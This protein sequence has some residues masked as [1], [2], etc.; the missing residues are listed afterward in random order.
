MGPLT[1][2]G[3]TKPGDLVPTNEQRLDAIRQ[4][5]AKVSTNQWEPVD[6]WRLDRH[7]RLLGIYAQ[8]EIVGALLA[9]LAEVQPRDYRGDFP[10]EESY[11]D[12]CKGAPLFAFAWK[13]LSRGCPMYLKFALHESRVFIVS[14]HKQRERA[15]L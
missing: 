8:S 7:L 12:V 2:S 10:P 5:I 14:F 11:E 9:A 1:G 13:S 3:S 4:A 6:P 15:S